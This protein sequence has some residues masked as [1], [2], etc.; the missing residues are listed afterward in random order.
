[1][2]PNVMRDAIEAA[3]LSAEQAAA[4]RATA[5]ER[6]RIKVALEK[7]YEG[8]SGRRPPVN[9]MWEQGWGSGVCDARDIVVAAIRESPPTGTGG[10][11]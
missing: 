1:M 5:A 10:D 6:E 11:S 9:P 2:V 8:G 4:D 7:L 3:I